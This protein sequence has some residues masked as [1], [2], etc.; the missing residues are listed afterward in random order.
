MLKFLAAHLGYMDSPLGPAM[1]AMLS[2]RR[3]TG[4]SQ[5]DVALGWRL[6]TRFGNEIVWHNGGA[7]GYRSCVGFAPGWGTGSGTGIVVLSNA[8]SAVDD[9]GCHLLDVR[10]PL[11]R[12]RPLASLVHAVYSFFTVRR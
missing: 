7:G 12:P 1:R 3:P 11:A 10:Y 4:L 6:L 5:C 8:N 2:A 9:I